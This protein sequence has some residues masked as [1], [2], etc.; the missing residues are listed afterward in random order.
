MIFEENTAEIRGFLLQQGIFG[1]IEER[2]LVLV[3][4]DDSE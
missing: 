2:D 3:M 1:E 4:S